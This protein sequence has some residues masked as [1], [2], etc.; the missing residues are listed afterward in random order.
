MALNHLH[1]LVGIAVV[2][3]MLAIMSV[4]T[5]RFVRRKLRLSAVLAAA[6]VGLHL[7]GSVDALHLSTATLLQ[8]SAIARLSAAAAVINAAVVLLIN[9]LREDRVPDRFPAILQDAL[10]IGLVLLAATFLSEQLL[11]TSAVSAVVLGFALQDTLGNAIAGLAIQSEKPFHVGHWIRI[12]D[13]EGRVA[14]VTWR[15]TKLRTKGGNLVILPNSIISK[16]AI[17]NFSE[18]AAPFRLEVDVGASYL[19]APNAVKDAMIEAMRSSSRVLAEPA[20]DV[21]LISFDGSAITYRARFWIDDFAADERARDQV[22][23]AIYYAFQRRNIEI[24][25]PIQVQYARE[26]K[27]PDGALALAQKEGLLADVDLF[28]TVAPGVRTEIARSAQL[29]VFG[30]G[31]TIVKQGAA[32]QSMFLIVSGSV[33]VRLDDSNVEVARIDRGGYFGEMSLLTGDPRSATVAAIDDVSA[34]EIDA[35]LF[36]RI[37]SLHPD[38]IEH[39]GVAAATRRVGLEERRSA[40]GATLAVETSTVIARMRRFLRL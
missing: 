27:E 21:I 36:R 25:W 7:L 38:A 10:V 3:A 34:L 6:Y 29:R 19:A 11:T 28:A 16:E 1:L 13:H 30:A 22:R 14:E 4:T 17:T 24:P 40:A 39:F 8:L 31:E 23:T 26:W 12:G 35:D 2:V 15:A 20:P 9:P 32:G 33:S 18:P 37:G 5:N